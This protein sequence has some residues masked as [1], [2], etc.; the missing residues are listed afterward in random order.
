MDEST[1]NNAKYRFSACLWVGCIVEL[2]V[3][4]FEPN[5]RYVWCENSIFCQSQTVSCVFATVLDPREA[6]FMNVR[7]QGEV[8]D[9]K[10]SFLPRPSSEAHLWR[11]TSQNRYCRNYHSLSGFECI[12]VKN[13]HG[14]LNSSHQPIAR[15]S[16]RCWKR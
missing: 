4:K 9:F 1:I 12:S 14:D 5:F 7:T 11:L 6:K 8:P 16:Q 15:R 3:F 13:G 10:K 2:N